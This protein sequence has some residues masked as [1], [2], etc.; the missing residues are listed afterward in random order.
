M[1]N[2]FDTDGDGVLDMGEFVHLLDSVGI[3]L[4]EA[5]AVALFRRIDLDDDGF[6]SQDEWAVAF[7]SLGIKEGAPS[8]TGMFNAAAV[9]TP[10]DA[11]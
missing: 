8:G 6:L 1:F 2:E 11:F 4:P 3:H 5:Q 9:L 7:Y 10:L